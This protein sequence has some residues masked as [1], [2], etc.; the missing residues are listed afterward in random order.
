MKSAEQIEQAIRD[1]EMKTRPA[2]D[3]RIL[4]DAEAALPSVSDTGTIRP[5]PILW[6]RIV[7][8][9]WFVLGTAAAALFAIVAG[10]HYWNPKEPSAT[11]TS[12]TDTIAK[13]DTDNDVTVIA[14]PDDLIPP[15]E[16]VKI[17]LKLVLPKAVFITTPVNFRV[18]RLEQPRR[19]P[20][21]PFLVPEGTRNLALG[22]PVSSSDP[23]PLIGSLKQITDGDKEA[24]ES[25]Y[26]E[27]N[28]GAQWVQIDLGQPCEIY[29]IV[30][31][32]FHRVVRVYF[33][34]IVQVSNDP[35]FIESETL[36]NNDHNNSSGQGVGN[37]LHYLDTY[38]GKLID[39]RGVTARY[40]R[41]YSNGYIRGNA[42]GELNHY[43]EVEV[44]GIEQ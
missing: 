36:F 31:W 24:E 12:T 34:V 25:S 15:N 30:F 14:T 19:G 17:P 38:E 11:T 40:V 27:I 32:H 33:D 22:K 29:A 8:N 3:E 2:T 37:D 20:R 1:L 9:P 5:A 10:L 44:Y 28:P 35:N 42:A 16:P 43:T 21:P 4:A 39:A 26:V 13:N 41:L 6:K 23:E 18:E 7:T